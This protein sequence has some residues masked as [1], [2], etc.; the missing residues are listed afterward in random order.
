MTLLNFET[1]LDRQGTTR[2]VTIKETATVR[3]R[4]VTRR[5]HVAVEESEWTWRELRDYVIGEIERRFGGTASDDPRW[6][7]KERAIFSS[8]LTRHGAELSVAI[9]RYVFEIQDGRWQ[10]NPVTP[11]QF[12]L[13]SDPYFARPIADRL[14]R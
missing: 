11:F 2:V 14:A 6:P 10:G 12:C 1:D 5:T 7:V 8:F 9:A 3:P 4:S 13:K